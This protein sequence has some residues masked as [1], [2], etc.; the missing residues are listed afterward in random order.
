MARVEGRRAFSFDACARITHAAGMTPVTGY[1]RAGDAHVAYQVFGEGG[2]LVLVP[3]WASHVELQWQDPLCARFL[4]RLGAFS[5][6]LT[7]D[8]RGVGMSDPVPL[9]ALPTLE[10][11]MDD[12]RTVMN[13]AQVDS[14]AV[15]GIGAGGPMSLLFAATHPERCRAL[16]LVNTYARIVAD[17]D[18]PFGVPQ[19][20]VSRG[21]QWTTDTWGSG[22][23]F[24]IAAP[25][26]R[27]DH[28]ARDFHGRLQRM[29]VSPGALTKMQAMLIG[30]DV[31]AVLPS[32][33]VPT[34]VVHRAGNRLV[35][36]AHGR[37]LAEHIENAHYVEV[38]GEDHAFYAGDISE[39]VD[40]VQEFLTGVRTGPEPD[41][42]LVTVLFTDIVASTETAARVG[43][44]AWHD[45]IDR[46]DAIVRRELERFRGREIDTAG[47]GFLAAF[48]GPA[49]AIKCAM[50]IRDAV[51]TLGIQVR[52]G[53]HTGE[54][55]RRGSNLAGIAVNTG[56]RVADKAGPSEV[57]VSR[58]V[59]DLVAGSGIRF[60]DRGTTTLRGVP[61]EWQLA[62]VEAA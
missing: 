37:Y 47:D 6:V 22:T 11:W 36:V 10:E 7:F 1:A 30:L 48:D 23:T 25:S 24:D 46:H 50:A 2:D 26:L 19:D 45:L 9:D 57:L 41:R 32:V 15:L 29:S 16:V 42:V 62:A 56:A 18:Y 54:A 38:P 49:R 61:G 28:V 14:A 59:M 60:L 39:I 43:D 52:A 58:T 12:V 40:E 34:L 53:V 8:K 21:L 51:R 17:A 31:R 27:T 44:T 20:F 3:E 13:A 35:P 5:R 33:R 4:D 55:E